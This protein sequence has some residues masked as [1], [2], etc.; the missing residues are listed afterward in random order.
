[1]KAESVFGSRVLTV[2]ATLVMMASW[3]FAQEAQRGIGAAVPPSRERVVIKPESL[4]KP[5]ATAAARNSP[6]VAP[7]GGKGPVGLE[8]FAVNLYAEGAF[9]LARWVIQ[10]PNGDVFVSDA[11][12]NNIHLL[13]DTNKDGKIDNTSER[14]VFAAG[15]N[16][17][18]GMAVRGGYFYVANTDSVVRFKYS[19]GQTAV[20]DFEKIIDLPG[21]GYNQHWTRNLLFSRD[22]RKLYVSVGSQTNASEEADP[23]RAAI[24]EYNPDGTGHRIFASGIR[25]PIG[26]AWHPTT[27]QLWTAVNERD[28]L[29]DDLVPDY[30]TSVKDGGF[31]GWPYSYIGQNPDP[32]LEG[33]RPDLI[34]K[35]LVPDL[36]VE[37]HSAALGLVFYTGSMFPREFQGSAF[38]AM[39]GSWNRSKRTGYKV[40][41]IPFRNGKLDGGYENFI[42]GWVADAAGKDVSGRP[43]GLTQLND[44]SLLVVDDAVNRIYRVTYT[45]KK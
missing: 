26:L 9:G 5:F 1:M 18:F 14:F 32:R 35:A 16:Q 12:A 29:G 20:S 17:P 25:N 43:V 3:M 7:A 24:S 28:Q 23:R 38:V 30:V 33:K 40:I 13:R 2:A 8:G 36:L 15:L 11:R 31:Y 22:G 45:G 4:P 10:G 44:G 21:K 37:P 34:A 19:P 6:N 39:H 42:T 41:R 27:G